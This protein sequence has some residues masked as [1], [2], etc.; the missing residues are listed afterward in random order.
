MTTVLIT[1]C[2]SGFGAM[3]ALALARRGDRVFATVRKPDAA[4]AL[5][6]AAAGLSLS[7]HILDVTDQAS[8]ELTR[9]PSTEAWTRSRP[10]VAWTC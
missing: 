10:P 2:S 4:R 8:I 5:E 9:R 3:T 1:G 7:A 6:E